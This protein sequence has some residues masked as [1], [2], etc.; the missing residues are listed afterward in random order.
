MAAHWLQ[1]GRRRFESRRSAMW[2][3]HESSL[4]CRCLSD[5]CRLSSGTSPCI[6]ISSGNSLVLTTDE[7]S[8]VAFQNKPVYLWEVYLHQTIDDVLLAQQEKKAELMRQVTQVFLERPQTCL[9]VDELAGSHHHHS[10][11]PQGH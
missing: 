4:L 6:P 9:C 1:H 8:Y 5:V 7:S 10:F 3:D 2:S 11:E